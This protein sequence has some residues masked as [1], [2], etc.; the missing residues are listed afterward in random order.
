[1]FQIFWFLFLCIYFHKIIIFNTVVNRNG[2]LV[3]VSPIEVLNYYSYAEEWDVSVVFALSLSGPSCFC[4]EWLYVRLSCLVVSPLPPLPPAQAE[5]LIR[6]F[7]NKIVVRFASGHK[8]AK[9]ALDWWW[10]RDKQLKLYGT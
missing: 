6:H 5:I 2:Q 10:Q 1:M 3:D 9:S 8:T 7:R 4:I